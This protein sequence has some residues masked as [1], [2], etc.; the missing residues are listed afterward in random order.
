M[1]KEGLDQLKEYFDD[2]SKS[3]AKDQLLIID[4]YFDYEDKKIQE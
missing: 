1:K 2:L 3:K 4:H